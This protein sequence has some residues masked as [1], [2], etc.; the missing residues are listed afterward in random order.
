MADFKELVDVL[1]QVGNRGNAVRAA[2]AG[3]DQGA[4]AVFQQKLIDAGIF[5]PEEL[6]SIPESLGLK[7]NP[8]RSLRQ[9]FVNGL[10]NRAPKP[11]VV[12][13]LEQR[14]KEAEIALTEARVK[15][16]QNKPE[17]ISP[18][19]KALDTKFGSVIATRLADGSTYN[20]SSN[21]KLIQ[22]VVNDLKSG[23]VKTGGPRGSLIPERAQEIF[24]KDISNA[25][26][27]IQSVIFK[28]LRLTMGAQ[29]TEQE[30]QRVIK[31]TFD[32]A[33]KPEVLAERLIRLQDVMG[34]QL[35][36]MEAAEK[37]FND[38]NGTLAGFTGN[39]GLSA[40]DIL[41]QV[42]AASESA[43]VP[44]GDVVA[45]YTRGPDG[46]LKRIR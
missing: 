14:Q 23:K 35:K 3:A 5:K 38:H 19:Q 39:V 34:R 2:Q 20:D 18:G 37:Y 33:Q 17:P 45:S 12:D 10:I 7:L 26:Q 4:K 36:N 21:R 13:P 43:T 31:A 44:T 41:T 27:K 8:N 40:D 1:S 16:L 6:G 29:F 9:E 25:R 11:Q 24:A 15:D 46:K 42:G 30:G 28:Q 32:S 22:G